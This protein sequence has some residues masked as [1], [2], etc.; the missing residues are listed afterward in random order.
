MASSDAPPGK[1]KPYEWDESI[2]LP[3]EAIQVWKEVVETVKCGHQ[4]E[5]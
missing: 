4:G 3:P 5:C 1:D 2:V